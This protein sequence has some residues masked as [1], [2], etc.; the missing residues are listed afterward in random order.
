MS[1]NSNLVLAQNDFEKLSSLVAGSPHTTEL[2]SDE[3]NR[4]LVVPTKEFP[5]DVVSMNSFVCFLDL[6]TGKESTVTLVYPHESNI[7]ENKI[8]ILAPIGS[9]LIGLQVGQIISW[10][11]PR[12]GLRRIKVTAV[13]QQPQVADNVEKI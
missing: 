1:T 10:P 3:L 9:A 4:A 13:V 11:I 8:S 7:N 6:D 12:G 2:L 5:A